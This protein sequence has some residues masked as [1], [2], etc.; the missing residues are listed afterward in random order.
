MVRRRLQAPVR[1]LT[2]AVAAGRWPSCTHRWAGALRATSAREHN[3][4][5]RLRTR[6]LLS[7]AAR[8]SLARSDR[9]A[10]LGLSVPRLER[11]D[12]GGVL[13]TQLRVPDPRRPGSDR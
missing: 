2:T 5:L 9:A 6:A 1:A 12:H 4:P 11:A 13:R 3:G 10:R 8:E 7:A